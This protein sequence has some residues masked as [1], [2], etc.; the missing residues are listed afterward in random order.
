[1]R[2]T[3]LPR[4]LVEHAMAY[5]S[6]AREPVAPQD[7]ATVVLARD[8]PSGVEVY[9]LRR[10]ADMA[11]AS[12][13][14]VFP[15]GRVDPR[16]ADVDL[17]WVGPDADDWGRM[18]GCDAP[19]ARALVCAAVRETFEESGILLAGRTADS[20][21]DGTGTDD[22]ERD[23][24][25]LVGHDLSMTEFAAA[26]GL[27]VRSDLLR[28]WAHWITPDFEP[29]RYD[30]RFFVTTVPPGQRPRDVSGE[31]DQVIWMPA[32]RACAE[33]DAGTMR[34]LPP[35]YVVCEELAG[36]PTTAAVMAAERVVRPLQPRLAFVDGSP[37]LT[38]GDQDDEPTP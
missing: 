11:F 5:V 1:V 6:G 2:T 4:Q 10:H 13:M 38:I 24:V 9:L 30:T 31:A 27:V 12:G 25:R 37:V 7:A 20:V 34:M 8:S 26:R 17:G 14:Y 33:V 19:T 23:R 18:L 22:W 29:R 21:V 35:T 16:D 3:P 15:G 28:A 36:L 32:A